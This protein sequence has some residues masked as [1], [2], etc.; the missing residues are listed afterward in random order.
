MYKLFKMKL[1]YFFI[2]ITLILHSKEQ[3]INKIIA[4]IG[5]EIILESDI[6]ED[7]KYFNNNQTIKNKCTSFEDILIKNLVLFYSKKDTLL[8]NEKIRLEEYINQYLPIYLEYIKSEKNIMNYFQG[9]SKENLNKELKN[10]ITNLF[11]FEKK[12]RFIIENINVSPSEVKDF[13]NKN[14]N[15]LPYKKEE[16]SLAHIILYPEISKES[17]NKAIEHLKYIKQDIEKG[18]STFEDNAKIYSQ[19]SISSFKGGLC[20][21]FKFGEM[22]KEFDSIA[23][24]LKEGEISNPFYTQIGYHIIK[25][26]KRKGLNLELRHIFL[27]K[28]PNK[29][30]IYNAKLKLDS[31]KQL[32]YNKKI[33]FE[34]A[35][36]KFSQD[37]STL[38]NGGVL[39]NNELQ[40]NRWEKNQL[41]NKEILQ[42]YGLNNEEMSDV[43][44]DE[45]DGK[46]V[47][48]LL[49]VK[50]IYFEHKLDIENDYFYIKN[51][52]LKKKQDD[53]F[54]KWISDQIANT[55][56]KIDNDYK[57]CN[58]N[59][60]WLNQ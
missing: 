16:I 21:N 48:R 58:F 22:P 50:K 47:V 44:E 18:F 7:L 36:L 17:K 55:F 1:N 31:I 26:E 37:E 4:V 8:E 30:E 14:K 41:T 11:F 20:K 60:N 53:I 13:F 28:N 46:N 35:V 5:N 3:Q 15:K 19:D 27:K 6:K 32:I 52:F 49:Q 43:F 10:Q 29:E 24:H 40:N 59:I 33:S 23:F 54:K 51:I 42:I 39:W 57:N 56:I 34:D 12:K 2:F 25:L 9:I 45:F 38:N